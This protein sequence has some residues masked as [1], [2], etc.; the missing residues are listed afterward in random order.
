MSTPIEL[1]SRSLLSRRA[2]VL[3]GAGIIAA[4]AAAIGSHPSS[5]QRG[6]PA[7]V[8]VEELMKPGD[9]PEIVIGKPDAPVT[10]VEYASMTCP[11]CATFHNTVLPQLKAK[12]I[13]TGKARIVFR[14]FPLDE[15][16][17]AASMLA[18]CVPADA[19]ATLIGDLFKLQEQWAFVRGNLVVAKLFD[20]A[21][22]AGFTQASFD[23]CLTDQKLLEQ[24][25][26]VRKRG[27][28]KFGV[29]STPTF[30]IN[31]RRLSGGGSMADFDKAL[32]PL[33]N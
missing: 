6:G 2:A 18:R 3:L 16:A 17:T 28:D 19:Q 4:A 30:F 29:S 13:D 26:A 32:A 23:K 8:P 14:E 12:Y 10:I 22:Q 24:V 20:V 25:E 33:V 21:K 5:A 11:H 9:L 7:T 15:R 27:A 31:G 1:L